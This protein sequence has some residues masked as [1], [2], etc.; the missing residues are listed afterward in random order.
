[1][2]T[3]RVLFAS[4]PHNHLTPNHRLPPQDAQPSK[5]YVCTLDASTPYSFKPPLSPALLALQPSLCA[6][7]PAGDSLPPQVPLTLQVSEQIHLCRAV[8]PD[9]RV[10]SLLHH[11]HQGPL[12]ATGHH[13]HVCGSPVRAFAPL[14]G[15]SHR[16]VGHQHGT[17][18]TFHTQGR[19]G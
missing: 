6:V 1:M 8:L 17:H 9:H 16:Q 15:S 13:F 11:H 5:P 10:W 19:E 12:S 2:G 3:Q 7:V 18:W 14:P 4:C